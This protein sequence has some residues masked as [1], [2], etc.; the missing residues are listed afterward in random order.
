MK[1][2]GVTF[3]LFVS[4]FCVDAFSQFGIENSLEWI[5]YKADYISTG[6]I[7]DI[8]TLDNEN[9][10]FWFSPSRVV[11]GDSLLS[12]VSSSVATDSLTKVLNVGV[13]VFASKSAGV[14]QLMNN[15]KG[16]P[17]LI[18][19]SASEKRLYQAASFSAVDTSPKLVKLCAD[20]LK[21]L[22]AHQKRGFSIEEAWLP[23][24][25]ESPIWFELYPQGIKYLVVP[26]FLFPSAIKK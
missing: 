24:A 13:F 22:G 3:L 4:F 19:S 12:F 9:I 11:K 8:D 1:K 10:M 14:P 2:I 20:I 18:R 26:A 17:L 15:L 21:L 25:E 6:T 23:I 16:L 7:Y 5:C